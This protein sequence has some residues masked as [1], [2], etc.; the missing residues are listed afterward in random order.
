MWPIFEAFEVTIVHILTLHDLS[1]FHSGKMEPW[2]LRKF[3]S[4]LLTHK[5]N[6]TIFWCIPSGSCTHSNPTW[7]QCVSGGKMDCCKLRLS[8][9]HCFTQFFMLNEAEN[10]NLTKFWR[11]WTGNYAHSSLT[12][13]EHIWAR[14]KCTDVHWLN[15]VWTM[16]LLTSAIYMPPKCGENS[17][18]YHSHFECINKK[19]NS[20]FLSITRL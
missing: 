19:S 20:A 15:F 16:G 9:S 2:K 11:I 17:G 18:F 13:Y 6:L 10:Q 7:D 4:Q 3:L 5:P 14:K 12:W 1:T 8:G